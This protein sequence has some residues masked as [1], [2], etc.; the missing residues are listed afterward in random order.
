MKRKTKILWLTILATGLLLLLAGRVVYVVSCLSLMDALHEE[1]AKDAGTWEDDPNNWHR[2]FGEDSPQDVSVVHSYY[3]G[4]DHF[5]HEYICYFEVQASPSWR[6]RYVADRGL[7][8]VA[9][10]NAWSFRSRCGNELP[11]WYVPDPVKQYD[12][13]DLPG[14]HGSVYINRTNGHMHFSESQL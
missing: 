5:T 12:V 14:Y 3:W 2:A 13:W 8:R 10:S 11:D 4:S 7:Q 9:E 1:S 6:S